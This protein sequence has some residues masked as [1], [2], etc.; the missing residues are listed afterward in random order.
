[1][2][3]INQS[4]I[5]VLEAAV[6]DPRI[7]SVYGAL[8]GVKGILEGDLIDLTVLTGPGQEPHDLELT[9]AQTATIAGADLVLLEEAL[10][11]VVADAVEQNGTGRALD[12]EDVIDL[13]PIAESHEHGDEDEHADE[14]EHDHGDEDP[15]FWLDPALMAELAGAVAEGLAEIDPEHAEDYSANA[16][17]LVEELEA[18]DSAWA[19]GLA[20]C[21]RD[22]VV[23]SHDA[24]G[25]LTRYGLD[26]HGIAGLSPDAEPTPADL[27]EL[28]ALIRDEG[29]TTVFSETLAPRALS[30]TL[31]RDAGVETAV[32]DPIEGLSDET[33]EEDYLSLMEANLEALQEANGCR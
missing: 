9:V 14:D 20:E 10:Q 30:E 3:V 12:V 15:H 26:F 31:A 1:T 19:S 7:G 33:A 27:G 29:I 18:L 17:A 6:A 23:V 11:P 32:L 5:G 4:L 8:H 13:Q 25:Y 28:Q 16:A 21:E 22:V 2:A 24:F